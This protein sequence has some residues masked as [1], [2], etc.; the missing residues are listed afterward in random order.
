M[1]EGEVY[2]NKEDNYKVVLLGV[3]FA[4]DSD[5]DKI[6]YKRLDDSMIYAL[7]RLRFNEEFKKE[8]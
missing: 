2:L 3:V 7:L 5:E 8:E 6:Y 1:N 4:S